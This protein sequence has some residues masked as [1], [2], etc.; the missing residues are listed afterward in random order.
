MVPLLYFI[1]FASFQLHSEQVLASNPCVTHTL[2]ELTN[3]VA[4][5]T[6]RSVYFDA[7]DEPDHTVTIPDDHLLSFFHDTELVCSPLVVFLC[8]EYCVYVHGD[9]RMTFDGCSFGGALQITNATTIIRNCRIQASSTFSAKTQHMLFETDKGGD[10]VLIENSFFNGR[11]KT[12]CLSFGHVGNV[13]IRNTSFVN[14]TKLQDSGGAIYVYGAGLRLAINEGIDEK[15]SALS[16]AGNV[17]IVNVTMDGCVSASNSGGCLEVRRAEIV[18]I[19]GMIV[20]SGTASKTGGCVSLS[21]IGTV[22][23][24][25]STFDTCTSLTKHGGGLIILREDLTIPGYVLL[26]NL[27]IRNSYGERGGGLLLT[28]YNNPFQVATT[29]RNIQFYNNT[30]SI[31]ADSDIQAHRLIAEDI[32]SYLCNSNLTLCFSLHSCNASVSNFAIRQYKSPIHVLEFN[33]GVMIPPCFTQFNVS[34]VYIENTLGE[35]RNTGSCFGMDGFDMSQVT[36]ITVINCRNRGL[37]SISIFDA[38]T[39]KMSNVKVVGPGNGCVS[40]LRLRRSNV[41]NVSV[42]RCDFLSTKK[43]SYSFADYG[44]ENTMQHTTQLSDKAKTI[45]RTPSRTQTKGS[46]K[47]TTRRSSRPTDD[48]ST[49]FMIPLPVL[50]TIQAVSASISTSASLTL[51]T[52]HFV[53]L[54]CGFD[55]ERKDVAWKS[56]FSSLTL[57]VEGYVAEIAGSV[58][59]AILH[60]LVVLVCYWYKAK[61]PSAQTGMMMEARSLCRH[62][63]F[64]WRVVVVSLP[65]ALTSSFIVYLEDS[66]SIALVVFIF[67]CIVVPIMIYVVWYVVYPHVRFAGTGFLTQSSY[68]TWALG[69]FGVWVPLEYERMYGP[70]FTSVRGDVSPL[71]LQSYVRWFPLAFSVVTGVCAS[72]RVTAG[73]SCTA[74]SILLS[75]VSLTFAICVVVITP[76]LTRAQSGVR[77]IRYVFLSIALLCHT[78]I[79]TNESTKEVIDVLA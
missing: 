53:V 21:R 30:G 65:G 4:N 57:D 49:Q 51:P 17:T 52:T 72:L 3:A 24:R 36:N 39:L 59:S 42:Q 75:I 28:D 32:S 70:F 48:P 78:W 68:V 27:H 20:K 47:I 56:V 64:T 76:C 50:V 71:W 29:L 22:V 73:P 40:I 35:T 13:T 62:P 10:S 44:T 6:C 61:Q 14:C 25:T 9:V 58:V 2:E 38:H 33:H 31:S 1:V 11:W 60:G 67:L 63:N 12:G 69:P 45:S 46:S 5:V 74:L 43:Y 54:L 19:E 79:T 41:S 77:G 23:V 15:G 66:Q 8:E 18:V 34:N 7:K 26:E 16:V 55:I 37:G